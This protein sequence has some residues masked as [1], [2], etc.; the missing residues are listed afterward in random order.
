M[1]GLIAP[2][3]EA[4]PGGAVAFAYSND[5][6]CHVVIYKWTRRD[7]NPWP[8]PRKGGALPLSYEPIGFFRK[9]HPRRH[10]AKAFA[11]KGGTGVP[12]PVLEVI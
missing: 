3:R 10:Y 9:S 7:L 8:P 2:V 1:H 5:T 4:T 11:E 12:V 6:V